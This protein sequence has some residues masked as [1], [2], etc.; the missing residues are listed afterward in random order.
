MARCSAWFALASIA[1]GSVVIA[2]SATAATIGQTPPVDPPTNPC[3]NSFDLVQPTVTGGTS[4]VV[5]STGGIANWTVTS[6]ST[7][8]STPGESMALKM[9]RKAGDPNVY[10]AVAQEG[11]HTLVAGLNSFPAHLL[12]HAGDVLGIH[13]TAGS[14]LF[15]VPGEN[16]LYLLNGNLSN[17]QQA[18][19]T[20][21]TDFRVNASAQVEPT[22]DIKLGKAKSKSN[23]TAVLPVTV[24][25][26][27]V[28]T[29]SG[30]GIAKVSSSA[31]E[32]KQVTTAGTVK[33]KLKA[34]GLKS[35]QLKRKGKVKVDPKI[36]FT[37][38]GGIPNSVF[39]KI[40][41]HRG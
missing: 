22:S 30:G 16:F 21:D 24:E 38:T 13:S 8:S 20:P 25:N 5:P 11:P 37:P 2:N 14:C 29:A 23:G 4:Y 27:G 7:K 31:V 32:A 28:L 26:P 34:K 35:R 10:Q 3:A 15:A 19:F 39:R 1:L 40:K 18:A 9:F 6:W 17:G 12:V 41:L 33:L 36:T